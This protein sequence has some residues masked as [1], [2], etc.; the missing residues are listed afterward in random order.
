MTKIK[1]IISLAFS[2]LILGFGITAC[3][4]EKSV[5]LPTPPDFIDP[6]LADEDD[7][8]VE[9]PTTNA[10]VKVLFSEENKFQEIDGFG[11]AIAGW[12]GRLYTNLKREE[13][14]DRLF[15]KNGLN[16][17]FYRGYVCE[18]YAKHGTLDFGWDRKYNLPADHPSLVSDYWSISYDIEELGQMWALDYVR[19]NFPDVEVLHSSWSPLQMWKSSGNLN[20]GKLKREHYQDYAAYIVDFIEGMEK[21]TGSKTSYV[22]PANEPNSSSASWAACGWS[23]EELTDFVID[24]LRPELDK[25]G[26]QNIAIVIGEHAWWQ[27][28]GTM[29]SNM[30]KYRPEIVK[31]NVIAAGHGYFTG[32]AKIVPYTDA[33]NNNLKVW[34]TE[35]SSTS[36]Y[37]GSWKDGMNWAKTFHT[38]LAN[39]NINSFMWW[40]GARPTT[41]NESLIRLEA[42][43]PGT[44]YETP[45]AMRYYTYGHFTKYIPI[46]SYRYATEVKV[47]GGDPS[48]Q[49]FLD[50]LLITAYV[51]DV[52]NEY[53]IVIVNLDQTV[54]QDII[55]EIE[56]LGI[57]NMQKYESIETYQWKKTKINPSVETSSRYTTILP[58]SVTTLKGKLVTNNETIEE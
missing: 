2:V 25:R 1:Y 30:I 41:N 17:K 15:G 32:D 38:Y 5:D 14:L 42:E 33:V 29:I 35:T 58:Y 37:D 21:A 22:S 40:A 18:T 48:I 11:C 53:A 55:F 50:K 51:D 3:N 44:Y 9:E 12:S 49:D 28:G 34:N 26:H 8:V 16:L 13:V 45:E 56:N 27:N 23:A 6:G 39:G 4:D 46:G 36:N 7:G 20:N 54:S 47:D 31:Q 57:K 43:I 52:N 19:K 10:K 24:N